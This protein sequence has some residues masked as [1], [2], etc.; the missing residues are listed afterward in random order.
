VRKP[1]TTEEQKQR[2]ARAALRRAASAFADG[3]DRRLLQRSQGLTSFDCAERD[4]IRDEAAAAR[5]GAD[6][7]K[8]KQLD[9]WRDAIR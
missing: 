5:D 2:R 8:R 7:R 4:R 3:I 6:E 9:E 1:E